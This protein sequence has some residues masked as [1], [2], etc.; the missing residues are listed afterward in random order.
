[1]ELDWIKIL[2]KL[3]MMNSPEENL[4]LTIGRYLLVTLEINSVHMVEI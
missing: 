1:M 3:Y 4:T 2:E